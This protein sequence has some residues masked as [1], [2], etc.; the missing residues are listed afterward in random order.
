MKKYR[1]SLCLISALCLSIIFLS[2]CI[3]KR[4]SFN[5]PRGRAFA[6]SVACRQCHQAIYDTI[7]RGAHF[8]ATME[9]SKQNIRGNLNTGHNEFVYDKNTKVVIED[10][11]SGI[12]QV[13]YIND[14]EKKAY[15]LDI[16]F[17]IRNAQT[18]LYWQDDKTYELP[19][20]YYTSIHGWA[21]SPGF[22]STQ[23][24]FNR[25][26][27][28]DCFECHSSNM[29]QQ[30]NA[31]TAGITET[32]VK[33][34]LVYGID[35]ERCHGPAANH[36]NYQLDN[37]SIKTAKYITTA[38]SLT[39]QQKLD[40]CAVCHSGNE[41]VKL[42]SRFRFRPGDTLANFLIDRL[43]DVRTNDFDVH[44]NQYKLLSQSQC[45][46]SST[47]MTCSTCHDPHRDAD[48]GVAFYSL[49][50]MSCHSE[51]A[52]NFCTMAASIGPSIKNN[53]ID[54]HMP[55][56]ASKA[57]SFQQAGDPELSSYQLRN[58]RIAVYLAE[59]EK[60]PAGPIRTNR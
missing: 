20:S 50:C 26:I 11:D 54:C 5:D 16:T 17:G 7:L 23:P 3:N 6:G 1:K 55:R 29:T 44:G 4:E 28:T 48:A 53:C 24:N 60:K 10:R 21:T 43:D 33:S 8:N 12:Y 40:M 36:V 49:K 18:W 46:L 39:R 27:G 9:A 41:K 30:L 37:P 42:E 38:S 19:V 52:H 15:R 25:F 35:C 34:S 14:I 2:R 45:Y 57:I 58:H 22:S 31:S 59:K 47:K 56:Q 32:M 13:L 51:A